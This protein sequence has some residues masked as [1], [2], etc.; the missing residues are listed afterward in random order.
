MKKTN[1]ELFLEYKK[2]TDS[3]IKDE[4]L[5]T[6]YKQNKNFPH[7]IAKGFKNSILPYDEIV[8][9]AVVGMVKSFKTY[10]P[11]HSKFTT[12]SSKLMTNEILM[13]LRKV[14]YKKKCISI[15]T[16]IGGE[17]NMFLGDMIED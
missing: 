14:E 12:Y 4:I 9:L 5:S 15:E 6:L 16:P 2:E 11:N 8:N 17:G 13:E 7:Q 3:Y 1:E 10:D